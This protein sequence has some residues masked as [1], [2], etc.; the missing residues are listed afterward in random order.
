MCI[1]DRSYRPR[2]DAFIQKQVQEGGQV[3]IVCPLIET[4]EG[5]DERQSAVAYAKALEQRVPQVS[6]GLMH[7]KLKSREK[8]QVME[9]FIQGKIQVLVSTTVIEA[10]SYTH[11]DVY[12][13]TASGAHR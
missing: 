7:G 8:E 12:K 10:V 6:I 2:L 4:E 9:D 5:E 11:L 1:R 13:E 3:Y